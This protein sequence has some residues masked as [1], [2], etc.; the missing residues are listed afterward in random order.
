MVHLSKIPVMA[1]VEHLRALCNQANE[2][3]LTV[4]DIDGDSLGAAFA[5]W[6]L[7]KTLEPTK[8]VSVV[9]ERDIPKRYAFLVPSECRVDVFSDPPNWKKAFVVLLDSSPDRFSTFG[10]SFSSAKTTGLIDHHHTANVEGF[11]FVLFDDV[12]PS[13]TLLIY[14][15]FEAANVVPDCLAAT[16]LFAGLVFDTSIFRYKLTTPESLIMSARLLELGVSHTEVIESLLLVQP[17]ER[18]RFRADM[19]GEARFELDG[20]LC[21]SVMDRASDHLVD[22]GGLVD[23]LIF[24]EGVHVAAVIVTLPAGRVRLSLRSRS[25]VNVASIA[26]RIHPTGG[27]HSRA[28]GVTIEATVDFVVSMMIKYVRAQLS[29]SA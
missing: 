12:C 8:S 1:D 10:P 23:D 26:K 17:W 18:V 28:A 13:T 11:D 2:T 6:Y 21:F 5:L 27:G 15:L 14:R 16:N 7:L 24:I 4:S 9:L 29:G 20:R 25:S 22:S 19:I 3:I